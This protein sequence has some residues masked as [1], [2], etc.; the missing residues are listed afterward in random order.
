MNTARALSI[1]KGAPT[2]VF[3]VDGGDAQLPQTVVRYPK[4]LSLKKKK[5]N[6]YK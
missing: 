3:A 4:I 2:E 5:R 1:R 6:L